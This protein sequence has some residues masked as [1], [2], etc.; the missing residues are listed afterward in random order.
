MSTFTTIIALYFTLAITSVRSSASQLVA[1]IVTLLS[2]KPQPIATVLSSLHR[3]NTIW[4]YTT[5]DFAA[6]MI[7]NQSL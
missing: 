1:C 3:G 7:E 6:L 5:H 2:Y 4:N